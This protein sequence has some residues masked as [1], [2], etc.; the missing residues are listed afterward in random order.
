[1]GVEVGEILGFAVG[2]PVGATVLLVGALEGAFVIENVG[3]LLGFPVGVL[4]DGF[5]VAVG[6]VVDGFAVGL[7][8]GRTVGV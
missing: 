3:D 2:V 7:P 6:A 5:P 8:V 1:M 4:D